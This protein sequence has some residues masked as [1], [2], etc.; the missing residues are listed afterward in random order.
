VRP[1]RG[2]SNAYRRS[3]HV[4]VGIDVQGRSGRRYLYCR[5]R[6]VLATGRGEN[7]LSGGVDAFD[8][9]PQRRHRA[10][11]HEQK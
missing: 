6:T 9:R 2:Q 1:E 8:L 5:E 3:H 4:R 7:G 10:E 11:C